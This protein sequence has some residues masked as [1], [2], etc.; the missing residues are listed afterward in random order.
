VSTTLS[1]A[2][3]NGE[4]RLAEESGSKDFIAPAGPT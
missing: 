3:A 2:A 1:D 4:S